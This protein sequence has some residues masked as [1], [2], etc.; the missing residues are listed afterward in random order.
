MQGNDKLSIHASDTK[1]VAPE[2]TID[3][4]GLFW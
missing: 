3:S 2:K 4:P 1:T